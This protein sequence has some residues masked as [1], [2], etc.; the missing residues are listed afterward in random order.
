VLLIIAT[1]YSFA[2]LLVGY[3]RLRG[4]RRLAEPGAY[5]TVDVMG[6]VARNRILLADIRRSVLPARKVV[7][8]FAA[9]E[10]EARQRAA[11]RKVA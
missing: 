7:D 11:E 9:N 2:A 3:V 5:L 4:T 10:E 1:G 6:K 8:T